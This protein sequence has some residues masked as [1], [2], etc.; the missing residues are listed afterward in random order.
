MSD[1]WRD[2]STQIAEVE[3]TEGHVS[4]LHGHITH[5]TWE[6]VLLTWR[7]GSATVEW[8]LRDGKLYQEDGITPWSRN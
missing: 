7:Y 1:W 6:Y 4:Y 8:I 2:D 5:E 3:N